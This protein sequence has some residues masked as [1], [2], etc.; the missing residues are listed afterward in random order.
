MGEDEGMGCTNRLCRNL[1]KCRNS[2]I[3]LHFSSVCNGIADCPLADDEALCDLSV[4]PKK[5]T[6]VHYAITCVNV[7]TKEWR[8]K[9]Q[10]TFVINIKISLS[11]PEPLSDCANLHVG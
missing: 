7:D 2:A 3:C 9:K 8:G 10:F 4:C 6:C 11:L 1:F 5:C